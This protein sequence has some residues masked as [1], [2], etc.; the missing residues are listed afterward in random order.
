MHLGT[1]LQPESDTVNLQNAVLCVDCESVTNST[2]DECIVCG[3]RALLSLGRMLGGSLTTQR[4]E[5]LAGEKPVLRFDL[6][7]TIA[8]K[9]METKDLNAVIQGITSV[10]GPR[11]ARGASSFHVNVEPVVDSC[12]GNQ[13]HAA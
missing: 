2:S 6:D 4:A 12:T 1:K 10:I 8:L 3:G 11:L 7:M 13:L 5:R 9:Q